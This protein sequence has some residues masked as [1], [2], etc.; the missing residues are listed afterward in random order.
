MHKPDTYL[1]LITR[2]NPY[3]LVKLR[4]N[5]FCITCRP[6]PEKRPLPTRRTYKW[7]QNCHQH[8]KKHYIYRSS[9]KKY[10]KSL[11]AIN[12]DWLKTVDCSMNSIR[13]LGSSLR[14]PISH[15][16]YLEDC[17]FPAQSWLMNSEIL[18]HYSCL[19][20]FFGMSVD[21]LL[22]VYINR[23]SF[24]LSAVKTVICAA[25]L[26][27]CYLWRIYPQHEGPQWH[28]V[29]MDLWMSP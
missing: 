3:S 22:I 16:V 26:C 17:C 6:E 8:T 29:T 10:E 20:C 1:T 14:Y 2:E 24:L 23:Q 9:P 21:W 15:I 5:D 19:I 27:K 13:F 4:A 18:I 7:L 25:L 28:I 12:S 11:C